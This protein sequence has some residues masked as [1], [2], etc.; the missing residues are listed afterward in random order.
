MI[1]GIITLACDSDAEDPIPM[2]QFDK[3]IKFSSTLSIWNQ[4]TVL[5]NEYAKDVKQTEY[6]TEGVSI[7]K[8]LTRYHLEMSHVAYETE[9]GK[10]MRIEKGHFE[11]A[12]M[13]GNSIYGTYEG[14]GN[15]ASGPVEMSLIFIVTGG[16]GYYES[17]GG[18]F[19]ATTVVYEPNSAALVLEIKG[20]ILRE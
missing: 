14:Y 1:F 19:N 7:T 2:I 4:P 12:G 9:F 11:I 6:V 13:D 10:S 18:N 3:Q 16:T 8:Y 20:Y 15:L 17:A 5:N